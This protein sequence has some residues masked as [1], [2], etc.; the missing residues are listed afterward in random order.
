MSCQHSR[1]KFISLSEKIESNDIDL[2]TALEA[3]VEH[4]KQDPNEE[5]YKNNLDNY[6]DLPPVEE[7]VKEMELVA[8]FHEESDSLIWGFGDKDNMNKLTADLVQKEISL[9]S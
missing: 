7:F 6:D 3:D 9:S 1:M 2:K 8:S 5:V 4:A